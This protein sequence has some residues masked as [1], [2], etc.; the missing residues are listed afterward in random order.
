MIDETAPQFFMPDASG[1]SQQVYKT[2]IDSLEALQTSQLIARRSQSLTAHE[3]TLT[4]DGIPG[5]PFEKGTPNPDVF[6]QGEDVV[7]DLFLFHEGA[8]VSSDDFDVKIL[9]KT[10]SRAGKIAW[11]GIL[12]DGIYP[13]P[14]QS[15]YYEVWIPSN[16][17]ANLLAGTYYLQVLLQERVGA[18]KGKYD[19]K[20]VI[21]QSCFNIEYSNFSEHPETASKT[22]QGLSRGD[23]EATWPNAPN[24]IGQQ[25]HTPTALYLN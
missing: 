11:Q 25:A 13:K 17:T 16:A 21:L 8:P 7:Y 10:S 14:N 3:S 24:T 12:E 19:R 23:A 4:I 15:G 6:Y 22:S 9:V 5:I 18:G 1:D 2:V 20:Y